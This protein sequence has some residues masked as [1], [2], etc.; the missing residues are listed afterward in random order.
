LARWD[1]T[2]WLV[3]P[4]M[5]FSLMDG[6]LTGKAFYSRT[7]CAYD[8]ITGVPPPL[9]KKYYAITT[10]EGQFVTNYQMMDELQFQLGIDYQKQ[11]FIQTDKIT[12]QT[13]FSSNWSQFR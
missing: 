6:R 11:E 1:S 7:Q 2:N 10:D 5:K 9:A 8:A 3:S 13:L 12:N 4:E